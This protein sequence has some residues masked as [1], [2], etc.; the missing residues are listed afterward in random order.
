MFISCYVGLQEVWRLNLKQQKEDEVK[1]KK[2]EEKELSEEQNEVVQY[3][4]H[5]LGFVNKH[6]RTVIERSTEK[7]LSEG[8]Y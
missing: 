4:W 7:S 1:E 6:F 8:R 2:G 3:T 5:L